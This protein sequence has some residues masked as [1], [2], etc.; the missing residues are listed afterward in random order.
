MKQIES[1]NVI[2]HLPIYSNQVIQTSKETE[3]LT[4]NPN[5]TEP[6]PWQSDSIGNKLLDNVAFIENVKN[7]EDVTTINA[8]GNNNVKYS[9]YPFEEVHS[10]IVK[11]QSKLK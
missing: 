11:T 9:Q 8:V 7:K 4:Y 6:Q 3:L 5:V 1:D 2:L 10:I